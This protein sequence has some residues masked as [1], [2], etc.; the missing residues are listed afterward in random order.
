[1]NIVLLESL[2]VPDEVL[3]ACAK[4]LID[5]GH[6]FN[7]YPKDTDPNVQIERAKDAVSL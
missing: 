7:A 3:N 2:G 5:A 1:M 6:T 4:P